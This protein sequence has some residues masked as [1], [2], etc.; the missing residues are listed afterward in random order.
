MHSPDAQSRST[1]RADPE[2]IGISVVWAGADRVHLIELKVAPGTT[3]EQALR[4]S[5][6]LQICPEID[7]RIHR[8]GIFSRACALDDKVARGDRVEVYRPLLADPKE[9]RR[10]RAARRDPKSRT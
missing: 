8:V 4:A 9:A 10:R 5:R 3:V 6:I 7:L 1:E 2:L